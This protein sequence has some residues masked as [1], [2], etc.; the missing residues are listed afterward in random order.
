MAGPS[1]VR[2]MLR[3]TRG[4]FLIEVINR[5]LCPQL[6]RRK[7][8]RR[9]DELQGTIRPVRRIIFENH[10][11]RYFLGHALALGQPSPERLDKSFIALPAMR[12]HCFRAANISA[13]T[14]M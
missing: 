2:S 4:R 7:A 1:A 12:P 6:W 13:S 5:H 10:I 11:L 3:A 14:V 8:G 9:R